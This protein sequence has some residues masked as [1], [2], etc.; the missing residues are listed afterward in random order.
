MHAYV[1]HITLFYSY[2]ARCKLHSTPMTHVTVVIYLHNHLY[3]PMTHVYHTHICVHVHIIILKK[4]ETRCLDFETIILVR[5]GA[6]E[7]LRQLARC[8]SINSKKLRN[9]R[10]C[11]CARVLRQR[12]KAIDPSC[13][14]SCMHALKK[15]TIISGTRLTR[16]TRRSDLVPPTGADIL[17]CL[18]GR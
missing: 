5:K 10:V 2:V 16:T 11:A 18:C 14:L 8:E 7:F 17:P 15:S 3:T 4:G 12:R 6:N 13:R 9:E 1:L